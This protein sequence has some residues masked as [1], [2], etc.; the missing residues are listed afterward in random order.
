MI[1][2]SIQWFSNL[3]PQDT[4]TYTV[5]KRALMF[6]IEE[7]LHKVKHANQKRN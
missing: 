6:W 4:A 5:S 2:A 7:L 1:Y 3:V